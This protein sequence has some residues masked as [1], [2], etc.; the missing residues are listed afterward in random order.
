MRHALAQ[1]A[2]LTFQP[3]KPRFQ[4]LDAPIQAGFQT[5]DPLFQPRFQC[6]IK[7]LTRGGDTM[8]TRMSL[9]TR[10]ELLEQLKE[11]FRQ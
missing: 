10:R 11:G 8:G 1:F 6:L 7:N 4:R 2:K 5:V 9:E 3:I